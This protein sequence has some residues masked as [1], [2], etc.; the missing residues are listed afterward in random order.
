M[1]NI[2]RTDGH[3]PAMSRAQVDKVY[4]L[5]AITGKMPQVDMPTAHVLHGGMY[6]RTIAIP[7]GVVLTGALIEIA[8]ILVIAGDVVVYLGDTAAR[9]FGY[10]VLAASAGRKQAF[11]A[12]SDTHLT[13][14]FATNAKTVEEAEEQFTMEA[15]LLMSRA[16]GAVNHITVTGE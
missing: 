14:V 2:V 3:I 4:A 7:A 8:T 12:Q 11:A 1:S 15:G 10:N 6:A 9:M 16:P 13:M 5:E